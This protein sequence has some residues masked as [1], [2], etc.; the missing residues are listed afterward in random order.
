MSEPW[1]FMC[2][3]ENDGQYFDWYIERLPPV[4]REALENCCQNQCAACTYQVLRR[5]GTD[6]TLKAIREWDA[7]GLDRVPPPPLHPLRQPRRRPEPS[8]AALTAFNLKQRRRR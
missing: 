3:H 1:D 8:L 5:Y 2:S 4:V 6:I 7:L